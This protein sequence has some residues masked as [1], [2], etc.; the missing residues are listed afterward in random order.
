MRLLLCILAALAAAPASA[1]R[2]TL[3]RIHGETSLAGP[4]SRP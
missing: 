2:L 3:D 4:A 1:E